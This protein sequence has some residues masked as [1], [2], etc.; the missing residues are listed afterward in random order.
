MENRVLTEKAILPTINIVCAEST[1]SNYANYMR[2]SSTNDDG[3]LID[4]IDNVVVIVD[5]T[6]SSVL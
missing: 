5:S 1:R 4:I 2:A 6:D 3:A